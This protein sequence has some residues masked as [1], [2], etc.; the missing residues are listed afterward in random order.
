MSQNPDPNVIPPLRLVE[1]PS[2]AQNPRLRSHPTIT[3]LGKTFLAGQRDPILQAVAGAVEKFVREQTVWGEPDPRKLEITRDDLTGA[4]YIR[5]E[6]AEKD[7][8]GRFDLGLEVRLLG[9]RRRPHG[10][11]ADQH[12]LVVRLVLDPATGHIDHLVSDKSLSRLTDLDIR[13]IERPSWAREP[14]TTFS[15]E[16]SQQQKAF[17]QA[18]QPR[19]S[20]AICLI[21]T[22]EIE[23]TSFS[24]EPHDFAFPDR[25]WMTGQYYIS[26]ER[27]E[28]EGGFSFSCSI[29]CCF[30]EKSWFE[31]QENFDYLGEGIFVNF[32]VESMSFDVKG[33]AGNIS[34]I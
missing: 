21:V 12:A 31:D 23:N 8:Q 26:D 1:R 19:L 28:M 22:R 15:G 4:Y 5:D 16:F 7:D 2:W 24:G 14:K 6:Y 34:A 9:E 10:G 33:A 20:E 11:L 25:I 29:K 27:Y 18:Q 3:R 32:D 13:Q 17:V 30:L